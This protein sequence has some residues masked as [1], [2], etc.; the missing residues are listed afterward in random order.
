MDSYYVLHQFQLDSAIFHSFPFCG[1]EVIGILI[2]SVNYVLFDY[3]N[4]IKVN[5][6]V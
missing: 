6:I 2:R 1:F 4:L 3:K 5:I